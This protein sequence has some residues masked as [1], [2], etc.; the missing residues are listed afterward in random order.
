MSDSNVPDDSGMFSPD[1]WRALS[2][3][4]GINAKPKADGLIPD[5]WN[6]IFGS[7]ESNDFRQRL[8]GGV[9]PEIEAP[10]DD[11][12]KRSYEEILSI[13]REGSLGFRTFDIDPFNINQEDYPCQLTSAVL[14]NLFG[15]EDGAALFGYGADTNMSPFWRTISIDANATWI[16]VEYLP[17]RTNDIVRGIAYG[18]VGSGSDITIGPVIQPQTGGPTFPDLGTGNT[19]ISTGWP[20]KPSVTNA[21]ILQFDDP[22]GSP[23]LAKHGDSFKLP[24]N[25]LF[26]SF[27]MWSP[28]IRIM[29]GYNTEATSMDD[30]MLMTRPAFAGGRGFLN[31][32]TMHYTP[33]CITAGDVVGVDGA[34]MTLTGGGGIRSDSLITNR[35]QTIFSSGGA[36]LGY[37]DLGQGLIWI[38]G[39]SAT[40]NVQAAGAVAAATF[41][42]WLSVNMIG[43]VNVRRVEEINIPLVDLR[44]NGTVT[45]DFTEPIR[46]NLDF[47]AQ[48]L[49]QSRVNLV[50]NMSVCFQVRGYTYGLIQGTNNPIGNNPLTPFN[51]TECMAENPYAMDYIST[52]AAPGGID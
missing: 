28:R 48:L 51:F 34:P 38:T 36:V 44:N 49:L 40:I 20:G 29:V 16:R 32:P 30:R 7:V 12:Y 21:V 46:V 13:E 11:P 50:G 42:A 1:Y 33:F 10:K 24:F 23:I 27:K 17:N 22:N 4:S 37:R 25:T 18:G 15:F 14:G 26:V 45:K 8:L 35:G 39:F 6:A 41:I 43:S 52:L 31:N 2:S 5:I 19:N 9:T 47:G 3:E